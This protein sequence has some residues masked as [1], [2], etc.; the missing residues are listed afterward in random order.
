[1]TGGGVMC[2]QTVTKI[3]DVPQMDERDAWKVFHS[4]SDDSHAGFRYLPGLVKR[5]EWVRAQTK[6]ITD[7]R[8]VVTTGSGDLTPDQVKALFPFPVYNSGFHVCLSEADAVKF[9][10]GAKVWHHNED[11]VVEKVKVRGIR[12]EGT[13][14][15][16]PVI[17]ADEMFVPQTSPST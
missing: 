8:P 3:F 5:G 13:Q 17:V 6:Q 15:G 16:I 9:D 12:L 4:S 10:A 7:N 1:M 14:S 11:G 2:L